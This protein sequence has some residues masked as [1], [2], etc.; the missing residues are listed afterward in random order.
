MTAALRAAGPKSA[1]LALLRVAAAFAACAGA[2]AGAAPWDAPMR[3]GTGGTF[4]SLFLEVTAADARALPAPELDLR[5][6]LAN[7]W[8][9]PL[10][11]ERG[12][13][14]VLLQ[15]DDQSE[16]IALSVRAPWSSFG[17]GGA[18]ARRS[19][20]RRVTT[21]AELRLVAHWGGWTDRPIEAWHGL[22][23]STDFQRPLHARGAVRVS[24][25]DADTGEGIAVR[26]PRAAAG[27]LV[28]RT[29]ALLAGGGASATDPGRERWGVSARLDLKVP[30]GSPASLGGSGGWDA[31]AALL[32]TAEL[33]PWATGHAL[34]GA[35]AVSRLAA[36]VPLRPRTWRFA[37]ELSLAIRLG[38]FT[39][40]VE[41][42][43][44]SSIFE[45]GWLRGSPGG[46]EEPEATGHHAAFLPQN[47]VSVG[48]RRGRLTLWLS[49]DWTPGGAPHGGGG[50]DWFYDSNV[51]DV[52]LGL[53]WSARL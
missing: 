1:G 31:G 48:L 2:R 34:A 36:P 33:A 50:S 38:G 22:V 14:R 28:L 10:I 43:L 45:G 18:A 35:V 41:D 11:V 9:A 6:T 7:D 8:S 30:V 25:L 40:L 20:W 16:A 24:L 26:S 51:P 15:A 39:V 47:R 53:A 27:D 42:R 3:L 19:P 32:G 17:A 5:W 4:G 44:S 37:A 21:A 52:A 46:A 29:Q 13:R 23:G 12:G 49:E